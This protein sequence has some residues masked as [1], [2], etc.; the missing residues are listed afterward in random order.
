M[1]LAFEADNLGLLAAFHLRCAAP[2]RG[3]IINT[4]T[5]TYCPKFDASMAFL[6]DVNTRAISTR[7]DMGFI[8]ASLPRILL[9]SPCTLYTPILP[10]ATLFGEWP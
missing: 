8:R 9:V 10:L 2:E 5:S 3:Y 6:I 7:F 4:L 1:L